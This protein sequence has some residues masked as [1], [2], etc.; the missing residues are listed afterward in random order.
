MVTV[1]ISD[2]LRLMEDAPAVLSLEKLCEEHGCTYEWSSG[3]KPHLSKDGKT[4]LCKS[5]NMPAPAHISHDSGSERPT[6]VASKKQFFFHFPKDR[7]LR[8]MLANQD[9]KGSVQKANWCFSTSGR[10]IW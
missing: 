1:V 8:S 2:T 5:E 4:M 10:E 3:Q 9:N 7:N 6:K